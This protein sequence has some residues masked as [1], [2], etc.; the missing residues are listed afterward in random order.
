VWRR[1]RVLLG[2]RLDAP[3]LH[4]ADVPGARLLTGAQLAGASRRLLHTGWPR[5]ALRSRRA[6]FTA[7]DAA[8]AWVRSAQHF[9]A[10]RP[11]LAAAGASLAALGLAA[12]WLA[13]S[14]RRL[15]A[16]AALAFGGFAC[17]QLT[18]LGHETLAPIYSAHDVVARA[19]PGLPPQARFYAV[20]Q[21][22]HTLPFYLGRTV[23]M[24]LQPDELRVSVT[25]EPEKY[26][27]DMNAFAAAWQREG[28]ACGAFVPAEFDAIRAAHGLSASVVATG[29]R[30]LIAC[31][32]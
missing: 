20:K 3:A 32:P 29:A 5:G 8:P 15:A 26:I 19:R 1:V 25:W 23:T 12:A 22:D 31:K 18:L 24:V 11:W 30:Y 17:T 14:S 10:Y 7:Q 16:V 9:S 6:A 2:F 28:A 27:A 13:W 4:P 21:Y